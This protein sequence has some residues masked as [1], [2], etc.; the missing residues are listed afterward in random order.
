M[1]LLQSGDRIVLR[2]QPG[3]SIS[4]PRNVM[5]R[6]CAYLRLRFYEKSTYVSSYRYS[7]VVI[8]SSEQVFAR[9]HRKLSEVHRC[10]Y[11]ITL[12]ITKLQIFMRFYF[13][14]FFYIEEA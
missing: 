11:F 14:L 7:M 12:A 3:K 1:K 13:I 9:F 6:S 4:F 5:K 8:W 10:Y 2:F